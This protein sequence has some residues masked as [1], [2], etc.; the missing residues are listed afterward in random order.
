MFLK[1][2]KIIN[3]YK[4]LNQIYVN[5]NF[6]NQNNKLITKN[7][8]LNKLTK[9]R[10]RIKINYEDEENIF[11]DS[12]LNS[13]QSKRKSLYDSKISLAET[14]LKDKSK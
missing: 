11:N 4:A 8:K 12:Q 7:M 10:E 1:K 6:N 3:Q 5:L 9:K 13:L 2:Y 14:L